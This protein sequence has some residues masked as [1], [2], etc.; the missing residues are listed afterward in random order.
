MTGK[1]STMWVTGVAAVVLA[2]CGTATAQ[3]SAL[4]ANQPQPAQEAL[5]EAPEGHEPD[6]FDGQDHEQGTDR[7]DPGGAARGTDP[8]HSDDDGET[9]WHLLP[10]YDRPAPVE[11][12]ECARATSTLVAC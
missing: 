10:D 11:Q 4:E 9:P 1:M 6:D 3:P 8:N 12:P 5:T 7:D 2:A